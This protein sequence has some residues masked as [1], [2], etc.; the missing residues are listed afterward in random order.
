M[1]L[2]LHTSARRSGVQGTLDDTLRVPYYPKRMEDAYPEVGA[3]LRRRD[4]MPSSG[5]L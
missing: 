4:M 2:R 5:D 3:R 1:L